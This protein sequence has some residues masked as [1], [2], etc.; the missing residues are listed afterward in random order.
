MKS[1]L[2]FDILKRVEYLNRPIQDAAQ[3]ACNAMGARYDDDGGVIGFDK[4]GNL[5]VGFNS[6]QMSWAYQNNAE[7]VRYGIN[8]GDN[9]LYNITACSNVNCFT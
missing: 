7:I 6:E 8:P 3:E 4:D 9:R 1:V 5:A 2:I